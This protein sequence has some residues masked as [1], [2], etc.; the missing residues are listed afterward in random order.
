M[1]KR[2]QRKA[3]EGLPTAEQRDDSESD[4]SVL[5]KDFVIDLIN[6]QSNKQSE[7]YEDLKNE[8][9][10]F[11]DDFKNEFLRMFQEM[12]KQTKEDIQ[13]EN[14][15]RLQ[16]ETARL[17]NFVETRISSLATAIRRIGIDQ[18]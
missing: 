4:T 14:D 11:K 2:F 10:D 7:A 1:S 9:K 3:K 17:E 16:Q 13:Q 15:A 5:D 12:F 18:G 8:F 6:K